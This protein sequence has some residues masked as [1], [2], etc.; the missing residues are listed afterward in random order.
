MASAV[1]ICNLGLSHFGQDANLSS[2]TEQS[3]E[4]EHCSRFYPIALNELLE[5]FDWSFARK[6]A[7]LAELTN[8][9]EDFEYRYARPADCLKERRVLPD[10][11]GDDLN[12]VTDF[13]REGSNIYSNEPL[14]TLV[15]TQLL[16]DTTKFSPL[17][18]VTLSWRVAA[19][20]SGPILKDPSGGVPVRM[21]KVSDTMAA[22]AKA[23]D[24]NIDR[25]RAAHTSTAKGAR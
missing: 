18:V 19:Y 5:E 1:D 23:S 17:F 13:Q 7:T 20:V 9:R 12:D 11:Y 4:A 3:I 15:Y 8:D 22:Q 25:K 16:T 2:L 14:A 24:A 10:G 21:R 6:R